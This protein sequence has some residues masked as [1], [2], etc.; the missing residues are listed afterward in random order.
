MGWCKIHFGGFRGKIRKSRVTLQ[1]L[2]NALFSEVSYSLLSTQTLS[3]LLFV[4]LSS[5]SIYSIYNGFH[6]L[7]HFVLFFNELSVGLMFASW[8]QTVV[9]GV[10]CQDPAVVWASLRG[11]GCYITAG[12]VTLEECGKWEGVLEG[13]GGSGPPPSDTQTWVTGRWK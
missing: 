13:D 10:T 6:T 3:P 1:I 4:C 9:L 8:R 12:H 5:R 7:G 11:D 2:M